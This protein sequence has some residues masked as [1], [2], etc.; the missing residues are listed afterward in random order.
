MAN[1]R[2]SI[3]LNSLDDAK[4]TKDNSPYIHQDSKINFQLSIREKHKHTDKQIEILNCMQGNKT[5]IVT[6]DAL[7]GTSKSYLA[8]LAALKLLSEGK[9]RKIY[10]IRTPC[11][12]S[13]TARIGTL[14]G[15]LR[16]RL[17]SWDAVMME[18]LE[19]F[20]PGGQI[21]KL[22]SEGYIEFL[23]PGLLRGR[24]F[25]NSIL[26]CDEA[27]N[28]SFKD[29]LL[30]SSRMGER[31]KMFLI[32]DSYQNDVG[33]KSGFI[34]FFNLINDEDSRQ[35]GCF[36]FEMKKKED[37]LRSGFLRFLMEKVGILKCDK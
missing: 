24:N 21:T 34:K 31:S 28:F 17:S 7:W 36:C 2:K 8:I 15:E 16:E 13:D 12:S 35:Q 19:E 18:K 5:R 11:E 10:Y 29:L 6:I 9:T 1:K 33:N 22:L 14:P 37:I 27:S 20:L 32:G 30:I 4:A 23:P 25:T 3:K 26:I